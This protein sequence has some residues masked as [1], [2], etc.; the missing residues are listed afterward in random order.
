MCV[1]RKG[2]RKK[3]KPSARNEF[4]ASRKILSATNKKPKTDVLYLIVLILLVAEQLQVFAVGFGDTRDVGDAVHDFDRHG[5]GV[6][7]V[8]APGVGRRATLVD[9]LGEGPVLLFHAH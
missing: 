4:D 1:W 7:L 9:V 8:G 3:N 2:D 5:V 6:A